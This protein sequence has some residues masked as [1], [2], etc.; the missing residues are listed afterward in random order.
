MVKENFPKSK[1]RAA[2]LLNASYEAM[3]IITW[4]KAMVLWLSEKVEVIEFHDLRINSA[5]AT[6]PIPSVIRLKSYISTMAFRRVRYSKQNVYLR[7]G[8]VCQYCGKRCSSKEL[9]IDHVI[10]LSKQGP[11][12]W[13]NVVTACRH[14]NQRKGNRTPVTAG[15]PLLREPEAPHWMTPIELELQGDATVPQLWQHYLNIKTG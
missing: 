10:P 9:T 1:K 8:H 5:R 2:L 4:Q 13:D 15:M 14:C 7:D 6:F 12:N 3:R 11:E